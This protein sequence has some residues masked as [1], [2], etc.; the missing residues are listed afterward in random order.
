MTGP[1]PS[2]LQVVALAYESFLC[3]DRFHDERLR[4]MTL[5]LET[6][7]GRVL[8]GKPWWEVFDDYE[9]LAGGPSCR[10][11]HSWGRTKA[12]SR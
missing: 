1:E 12:A 9:V 4:V 3:A 10:C 7:T 5:A 8:G 11:G 6:F 2:L